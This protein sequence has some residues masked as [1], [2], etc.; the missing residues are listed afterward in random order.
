[1]WSTIF[2]YIVNCGPSVKQLI[3]KA[4][5]YTF[6]VFIWLQLFMLIFENR[7]KCKAYCTTALIMHKEDVYLFVNFD[8]RH[9][10]VLY[11]NI[12]IDEK[13]RSLLF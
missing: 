4:K 1:M 7:N 11:Y 6:L 13:M 8:S 5:G 10:H 3:Q 9:C 12:Q 2:F